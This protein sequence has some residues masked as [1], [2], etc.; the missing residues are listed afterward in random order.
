MALNRIKNKP[1]FPPNK[2]I[3]KCQTQQCEWWR[4]KCDDEVDSAVVKIFE[5]QATDDR[6]VACFLLAC[7]LFDLFIF[8]INHFIILVG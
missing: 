8:G 1:N 5:K 4:D 6:P 3:L 7:C 2:T